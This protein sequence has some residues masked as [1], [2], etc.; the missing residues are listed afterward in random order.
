MTT[1]PRGWR[2]AVLV[3]AAFLVAVALPGI[4]LVVEGDDTA[5]GF[6]LSTYPMFS[7]D[8]GTLIELPTVVAYT[9][10]G[11]VERLSPRQ[12]AGTDQVVQAW[13]NVRAAVSGGPR[14]AQRLCE[15]VAD[16]V[17]SPVAVVVEQHDTLEWSASN[18]EAEPLDRRTVARCEAGR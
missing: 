13:E 11:S 15:E 10:D 17:E 8:P 18:G 4:R 1:R 5:D 16:R 3:S 2:R 9:D 12:I 14:S 7:D 6:P